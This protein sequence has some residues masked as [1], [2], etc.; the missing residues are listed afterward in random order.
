MTSKFK[1]VAIALI[2]CALSLEMLAS[3]AYLQGQPADQRRPVKRAEG[4]DQ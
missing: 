3:N 2:L 4:R 1:R